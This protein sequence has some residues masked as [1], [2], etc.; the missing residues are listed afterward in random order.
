M[1]EIRLQRDFI[2]ECHHPLIPAMRNFHAYNKFAN[3]FDHEYDFYWAQFTD[4]QY[5]LFALTY[6]E[7][8]QYFKEI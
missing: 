2:N 1:K 6:P 7:L 5:M 3:G 4:E 8:A